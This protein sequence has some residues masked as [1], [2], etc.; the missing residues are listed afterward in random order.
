MGVPPADMA[1]MRL[2]WERQTQAATLYSVE[3]N[4]AVQSSVVRFNTT[5]LRQQFGGHVPARIEVS[6][7]EPRQNDQ[8][9][10]V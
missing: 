4:D 7:F 6:L 8:N 3:P 10:A 1:L 5:W 2:T 9:L